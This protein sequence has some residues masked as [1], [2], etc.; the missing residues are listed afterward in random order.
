VGCALVAYVD[1]PL[2]RVELDPAVR[3]GSR[4]DGDGEAVLLH[5]TSHGHAQE[6]AAVLA[7]LLRSSGWRVTVRDFDAL[8]P[9]RDNTA[10]LGML[11]SGALES[12]CAS[13]GQ[14]PPK[15][16]RRQEPPRGTKSRLRC[17]VCLHLTVGR[18]VRSHVE[19]VGHDD[20]ERVR[21]A[22]DGTVTRVPEQVCASGPSGSASSAS[23]GRPNGI[24]QPRLEGGSR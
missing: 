3:V 1:R 12:L 18:G 15:Q 17:R 7:R 13:I 10:G 16:K 21:V 22:P 19:N 4:L 2:R 20:W 11:P 24:T 8:A 9:V 6:T 14:A 23:E 5:C